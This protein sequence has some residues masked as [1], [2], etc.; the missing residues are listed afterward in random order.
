MRGTLQFRGNNRQGFPCCGW[1]D[2]F[3]AGPTTLLIVIK[4][5]QMNNAKRCQTYADVIRRTQSREEARVERR[6]PEIEMHANK[7][8]RVEHKED[9][10]SDRFDEIQREA[11]EVS[12]RLRK[13]DLSPEE[14]KEPDEGMLVDESMSSDEEDEALEKTLKGLYDPCDGEPPRDAG[15]DSVC[16]GQQNPRQAKGG[17]VGSCRK[18]GCPT[19]PFL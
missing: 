11:R 1:R 9:R 16:C 5:Y 2:L 18:A 14:E 4:K 8:R 13:E 7:R 19:S 3:Q 12:K 17:N 6:E 15:E 10:H